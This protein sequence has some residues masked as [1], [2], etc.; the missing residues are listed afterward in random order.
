MR[1]RGWLKWGADS[2]KLLYQSGRRFQIM[3]GQA[4]LTVHFGTVDTMLGQ[5]DRLVRLAG[6][7]SVDLDV[8]LERSTVADPPDR[9][10]QSA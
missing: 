9:R 8:L 6:L 7:P 4:A 10:I 5:L 2:T 3:L 1:R